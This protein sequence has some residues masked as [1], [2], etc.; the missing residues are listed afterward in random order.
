MIIAQGKAAEAAA[1][2]KTPNPPST[3]FSKSVLAPKGLGAKPD[4]E[5]LSIPTGL[6]HS[7]QGCE[8]RATLGNRALTVI[9][10]EPTPAW[11]AAEWLGPVR[12]ALALRKVISGNFKQ[13][14]VGVKKV[15][16]VCD[17]VVLKFER[18]ASCLKF[19][20]RRLEVCIRGGSKSKMP[21]PSIG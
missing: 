20:L 17:F 5:T 3:P 15:N 6:H 11:P 4:S 21:G 1:L 10:R 12:F 14:G 7:A 2:G 13:E 8:E 19:F 16:R 18:N 9:N